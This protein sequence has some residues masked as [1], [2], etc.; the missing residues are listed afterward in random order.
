MKVEITKNC[1]VEGK[2]VKAGD[3]VDTDKANLL[4]GAGCAKKYVEPKPQPKQ[5]KKAK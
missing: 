2:A 1:Y 4:I 3:V 5:A